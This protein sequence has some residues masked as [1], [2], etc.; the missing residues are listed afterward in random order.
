MRENDS[1]HITI[2]D[3]SLLQISS[4]HLE[5]IKSFNSN[6]VAFNFVNFQ[7]NANTEYNV[8]LLEYDYK[9]NLWWSGRYVGEANFKHDNRE[10]KLTIQPRFGEVFLFR[11]FEEI[12]NIRLINSTY[13]I[14]KSTDVHFLIRKVISFIWV[15]LL[16][17]ANKHGLPT[18]NVVRTYEGSKIKGKL[19]IR[20]TIHSLANHNLIA[21][22]YTEK[23]CDPTI[24][25]IILKAYKLLKSDFGLDN[26]NL[27]ENAK[28]ALN[29]LFSQT[30]DLGYISANQ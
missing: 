26:I 17:T 23:A 28:D 27:P 29:D 7:P 12:Y 11:M 10:Y 13:N 3:C 15:Q 20:R 8:P 21:S 24:S 9:N 18:K 6:A 4:E 1:I 30:K 22:N 5:A 16:A 19:N 14:T 2:K 25:N